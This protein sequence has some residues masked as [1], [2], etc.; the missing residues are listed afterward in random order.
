MEGNKIKKIKRTK[1][2]IP[3]N[4]KAKKI[5]RFRIETILRQTNLKHL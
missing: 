4:K 2:R 1:Q 5:L 3:E